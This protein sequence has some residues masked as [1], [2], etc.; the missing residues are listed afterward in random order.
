MPSSAL[1]SSVRSVQKQTA[2]VSLFITF[3]F[4]ILINTLQSTKYTVIY[5]GTLGFFLFFSPRTVQ[6][7]QLF[8][9]RPAN[10]RRVCARWESQASASQ[11]L[12]ACPEHDPRRR[13]PTFCS[14]LHLVP[15]G[16]SQEPLPGLTTTAFPWPQPGA[17]AAAQCGPPATPHPPTR[18]S[19]HHSGN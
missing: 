6:K 12:A 2:Y 10:K 15:R 7:S 13:S 16:G 4:F 11:L 19:L 8:S 5:F 18:D 9:V 17:G 14:P 1:L 3:F